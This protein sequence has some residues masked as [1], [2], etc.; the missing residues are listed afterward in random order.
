[1]SNRY[2]ALLVS[3][4][5]SPRMPEKSEMSVCASQVSSHWL[6]EEEVGVNL[7]SAGTYRWSLLLRCVAKKVQQLS[8]FAWMHLSRIAGRTSKENL[9]HLQRRCV[10]KKS[11]QPL[12][13]VLGLAEVPS[14]LASLDSSA[15]FTLRARPIHLK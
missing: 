14:S 15:F 2:V 10:A 7:N 4:L 8:D 3:G 11:P 12:D 1:M 5:V 13:R 9:G 6:A